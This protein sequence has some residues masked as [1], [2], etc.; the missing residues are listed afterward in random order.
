[1]KIHFNKLYTK[2]VN[3][4]FSENSRLV[5]IYNLCDG[6]KLKGYYS[7]WVTSHALVYH[8]MGSKCVRG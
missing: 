3:H 4:V 2:I 8:V 5:T 1:M 6:C 7:K